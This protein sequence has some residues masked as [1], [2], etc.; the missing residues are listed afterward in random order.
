M[1]HSNGRTF[2]TVPYRHAP[3]RTG[4]WLPVLPS[5]YRP[6]RKYEYA[7]PEGRGKDS[8]PFFRCAPT[9]TVGGC[10]I[11]IINNN[12]K[13]NIAQPRIDRPPAARPPA[14]PKRTPCR[15]LPPFWRSF[16]RYSNSEP[17]AIALATARPLSVS[18][19]VTCLWLSACAGLYRRRRRVERG[20]ASRQIASEASGA[21]SRGRTGRRKANGPAAWQLPEVL[22]EARPLVSRSSLQPRALSAQRPWCPPSVPRGAQRAALACVTLLL[23]P[24]AKYRFCFCA[25]GR[26][27]SVSRPVT[28]LWLAGWLAACAGPYR[29]RRLSPAR[30]EKI[31]IFDFTSVS[32]VCLWHNVVRSLQSGQ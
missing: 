7:H 1:P 30:L 18:R 24:K 28:C 20:R 15:T 31:S 8:T 25:W 17:C 21:V 4:M 14:R 13:Y 32:T 12:N 26:P 22:L 10:I 9:A 3:P 6:Q 29:R 5:P 2:T 23:V 27:L 16:S 19:P 11:T